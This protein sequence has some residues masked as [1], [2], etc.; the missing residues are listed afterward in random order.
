MRRMQFF[1]VIFTI[2]I[3]I[4][5][6]NFVVSEKTFA[7]T[8][9]AGETE[10]V[11]EWTEKRY[12]KAT[13][14]GKSCDL[15]AVGSKDGTWRGGFCVPNSETSSSAPTQTKYTL[16]SPGSYGKYLAASTNLVS[17]FD[18]QVAGFFS[19][20][21]AA[22]K[23][24]YQQYFLALK[25][26]A[27][28]KSQEFASNNYNDGAFQVNVLNEFIKYLTG[29]RSSITDPLLQKV[30]DDVLALARDMHTK[31]SNDQLT[32]AALIAAGGGT[33]VSSQSASQLQSAANANV[34]K[35]QKEGAPEPGKCVTFTSFDLG[36]CIDA[37][38]AWIITHTLLAIAGW[39]LW[40]TA[41]VM[42]YAINVGILQFASWAPEALYP[43][44]LVV[45][46]I[47]SLFVVFAGLWLGF[48][49]IIDKGDQFKK[50]I[51]TVLIFALFVNF[52]YP[53]T[54]TVIDISN[55][56]SLN[57]YAST[58]GASTLE[59]STISVGADKTAGT[60][61]M[62][63]LGLVGVV[64]YALGD[65]KTTEGSLNSINSV[66]PALLAVL[67]I[68]YAAWIFFIISALLVTRTAVLVFLIIASPLLFVDKVIPKLGEH[69][70]KLRGIFVEMLFVGPVF[71]IMLAL[72][73]KFLEVFQSGPLKNGGSIS[74]IAA[75]GDGAITMFFNMLMMLI[76]LH[77]MFKVTKATA[78]KIG[79]TVAG[80]ASTVGGA[81]FGGV[82]L[83]GA[84]MLGRATLGR[85]AAAARDSGWMQKAQGGALGRHV[86][87]LS[88]TFAKGAYDGRNSA[89]VKFGASKLGTNF[90]MGGTKGREELANEHRTKLEAHLG[91]VGVH[92]K[93]VYDADGKLIAE[94]GTI[95]TSPQAL[96]A[97]QRIIDGSGSVFG[98][99]QDNFDARYQLNEANKKFA[100]AE[101]SKLGTSD[102]DQRKAES[103]LARYDGDE[104]MK[105]KLNDAFT[106]KIAEEFALLDDAGEK[107]A[108][109]SRLHSADSGTKS[110]K[111]MNET[112]SRIENSD[113]QKA[114]SEY[115]SQ[116]TQKAK[117]DYAAKQ[118]A[119][120]Q[121]AIIEHDLKKE[122]AENKKDAANAASVAATNAVAAEQAKTTQAM[123]DL[124]AHFTTPSSTPHP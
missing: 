71:T 35:T 99:K 9:P 56:I 10:F 44:W 24:A 31:A 89:A 100:L 88:D 19:S 22:Q 118:T 57:I 45:R 105:K 109:I 90:G 2:L 98:S 67:F 92:Q 62:N 113:T 50:Y 112:A 15:K 38:F 28:Q 117:D 43:V 41:T 69:A 75:G 16:P 86:Y 46:Q 107:L 17:Y 122:K 48:M 47:T 37:F 26:I 101:M 121:Q 96:A 7:L 21:N 60:L 27:A 5:V 20:Y 39:L 95:D 30:N 11:D 119:Q 55:I 106:K 82:A 4:V 123:V 3:G 78:G 8:C 93:N 25:G 52:S 114:I 59:A 40:I 124:L 54:R 65:G 36:A 72:T 91:R 103:L 83:G 97:R 85:A 23:S 63:K 61:I 84:G 42:N 12:C 73:L 120:A 70:T 49:Y 58:V 79:E 64:D 80:V 51:P 111:T 76:M 94:K 14:E 104:K 68:L 53:L 32:D 33:T 74:S 66:G 115:N 108:F 6:S 18:P 77:I 110:G 102:E 13:P 34:A 116:A 81:A 29:L 1:A 87:N